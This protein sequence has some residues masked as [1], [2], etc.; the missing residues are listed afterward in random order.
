[1]MTKT[2][3]IKATGTLLIALAVQGC[4]GGKNQTNIELVQAMM[5]QNSLKAQDWDPKREGVPGQLV[6]PENTIPMNHKPYKYAGNPAA[7]EQNLKN[8]FAGDLSPEMITKGEEHYRIYCGVCHG[9]GG[10][11]DGPVAAA[12]V[13]KPPPLVSSAVKGYKDGLIFHF[14]TEEKV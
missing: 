13:L 9:A 3:W 7:A 6:P 10:R 2:N 12:M 1:M 5:D 14:I 11:G 4:N 8:P